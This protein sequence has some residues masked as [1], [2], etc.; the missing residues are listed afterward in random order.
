MRSKV[1]NNCNLLVENRNIIHKVFS[2]DSN[3]MT[4]AAASII[5]SAGVLASVEKL[6][7]CKAIL[8]KDTGLLS[9]FRGNTKIPLIAKMALADDPEA[10]L[11][12]VM[13][14]Y[15]AMNSNKLINS[16]YR[17]MAAIAIADQVSGRHYAD[18]IDRTAEIYK[19]MK[20][21]HSIL[22]SSEDI[23]FAAMLALSNK[24]ID[25]MIDDMERSYEI[26]YKKFLDKNAVQSLTHILTLQDSEPSIKCAKVLRVFDELKAAGHKFGTSYE[27]CILG[28]TV[29][30]N[31]QESE[32]AALICEADD[33]LGKHK[34]FGNFSFG[35]KERLMIATQMVVSAGCNNSF[36][37]DNA[38][39]NSMLA[40]TIAIETAMLIC[41]ISA[42][43][44]AATTTSC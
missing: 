21:Q 42:S 32:I 36:A 15:D 18:Y 23:P 29:L 25:A 3:Y 14:I 41:A 20:K 30:L 6:K 33:Y 10:Y 34:G 27:L 26:L 22:T 12:R 1:M 8:K 19:K 16:E 7:T 9:V 39:M 44:S 17:V 11:D 2:W 5:T 31:L 24:D 40:I 37:S 13:D 28:T 38:I 43:T 4:M 35:K